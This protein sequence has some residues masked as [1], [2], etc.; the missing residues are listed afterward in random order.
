MEPTLVDAGVA[1][2]TLLSG[3]L[4]YTRGL[5]REIFAIGGWILAAAAAF[6]LTPFVEPFMREAPVIGGFFEDNCILSAVAAFFLVVAA[7]LL[8]MS[9]F[10]PILASAI[11]DSALGPL[12]R[13][14]G[15]LFGA[16]RGLALIAVAYL[17]YLYTVNGID[18]AGQLQPIEGEWPPLA[19]AA[20][21]GL[22]DEAVTRLSGFLPTEVPSWLKEHVDRLT[23]ICTGTGITEPAPAPAPAPESDS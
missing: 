16:A 19:N 11:L 23:G 20:S 13:V 21:R 7:G 22:F 15:F 17:I 6:Y 3:V 9:V 12:D 2:I 4:A 5:T 18:A 8:V 14:L 1:V 10:T